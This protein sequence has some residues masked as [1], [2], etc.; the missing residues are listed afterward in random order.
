MTISKSFKQIFSLSLV[1]T[2]LCL[3][4]FSGADWSAPAS[5]GSN[6]L[7]G[8]NVPAP[9]NVGSDD[10]VKN[11]GL[12]VDAFVAYGDSVFEDGQLQFRF[13]NT[14]DASSPTYWRMFRNDG[15]GNFNVYI[16]S[17]GGTSPVLETA[18][19]AF[20][21]QY[22]PGDGIYTFFS[23]PA[24]GAVGAAAAFSPVTRIYP[25]GRVAATSYCDVNGNNCATTLA[26]GG[27][28]SAG[29]GVYVTGDTLGSNSDIEQNCPA[30]HVLTGMRIITDN[31]CPGSCGQSSGPIERIDMI[32]VPSG[33]AVGTT[34]PRWHVGAWGGCIGACGTTGV[35]TRT[36]ECRRGDVVADDPAD[37]TDPQPASSQACATASCSGGGGSP[38]D[39]RCFIAG[40]QVTMADG[41]LKN[42]ED[43]QVGEFVLGKDGAHNEVL[44][45]EQPMLGERAL[46]S[47][48]DGPFFVTP[49]HPFYTTDGW[50]SINM[51]EIHRENTTLVGELAIT[52]LQVGDEIVRA[53]GTTE[54]VESIVGRSEA[55]QQLYNFYLSGNKT[56][57]VD[58]YLTHDEFSAD[59]PV[60]A[61]H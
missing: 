60:E 23:T 25:D 55:D 37:C 27:S 33:A 61:A 32:C 28:G 7:A 13:N 47:I 4:S 10:Q 31:S 26:G 38:G 40:T 34:P 17:N 44:A 46:Y 21:E 35:Q 51:D 39:M 20:K 52:E 48:N 6:D 14:F 49:A 22:N 42:I 2:G 29:E 41:T 12:S 57:F 53:D 19:F 1:L 24:Q 5:P 36:V 3:Y 58:G 18:G 54:V 11:G 50:K 56:Y 9:I 45:L 59:E 16:N 8:T 30:D 43:V 15:T